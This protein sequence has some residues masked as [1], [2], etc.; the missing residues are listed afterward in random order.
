M[1]FLTLDY[2]TKQARLDCTCEAE[3]LKIYGGA[4]EESILDYT[5]RTYE[6]LLN[7]EGRIPDRILLAGLMLCDHW[8]NHRSPVEERIMT[9]VPLTFDF[10]IK[11]YVKL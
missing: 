7:D 11:P 10:L 8:Y 6:E 9:G 1:K 5:N 4:A 2:I 3:A